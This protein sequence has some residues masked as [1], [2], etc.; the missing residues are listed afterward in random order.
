MFC[1][2]KGLFTVLAEPESFNLA[3]RGK[4]LFNAEVV[5]FAVEEEN[6]GRHHSNECAVVVET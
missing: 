3:V 5:C 4:V 6:N 2:L 1:S